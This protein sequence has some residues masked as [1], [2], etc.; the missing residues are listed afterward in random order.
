[1][2]ERPDVI[3]VGSGPAGANA[4]AALVE[5]GRRVLMLDYGDTDDR[6][7]QL[8]PPRTFREI[9]ESDEEQ[10][11]Y[12]LGDDFEGVPLGPLSTGAQLTPP[13][14]HVTASA[15]REM[16]V[17]S[18]DFRVAESLA[19]GGLGG[20]WGAG[21]FPF[22]DEELSDW[23]ISLADLL[24]HYDAVARRIGISVADDD[25]ERFFGRPRAAMPPLEVDSN[26]DAVLRA[27]SRKR[28]R[29]NGE[30]FFLGRTPLA[31]CTER[32]R[33]RGPESYRDMDFW[34]DIDRSVYRPR[35]TIA[36][37]QSDARGLFDYQHGLFVRR[38]EETQD[39]VNV[40]ASRRDGSEATFRAP[41]LLLGAG[42]LSTARIVLRSLSQ[43]RRRVPLLCN[44]YTYA[45]LVNLPM[46]G[47]EAR[48][49][50]HSLAQL[51]A[52]YQPDLARGG[53]GAVQAQLYSWRT[54]LTFRLMKEAPIAHRESL[55]I[56][57]LLMTAFG[58][59]G[60][61]HEDRRTERK[62]CLLRDDDRL[63]IHYALDADERARIESNERAILAGF[64][65]LGCW[66]IKR[67]HPGNGSSIHYAGTFPMSGDAKDGT[68]DAEG[69]L[70]G[71]RAVYLVD[72]SSFPY[73][74]AK[75]LT[76]TIMAN[77]DRVASRLALR[78]P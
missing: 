64:R 38:F 24:P 37:L 4:A 36:E 70:A 65:D 7:A 41:A 77:A 76:F 3:V 50:R 55:R 69:R 26:A 53:R 2:S 57:R 31:V 27:Y 20:A 39:G 23:P 29:L 56:M 60:I 9:R 6:Y 45:P 74:P 33:D 5:R 15:K 63:E 78:L 72:G 68:T 52:F 8:I 58:V 10:H 18:E 48:D 14:V 51:S 13:R 71:T 66:T 73:L 42:T 67:V 46:L 11:R 47:R 21:V 54:L 19:L 35:W 75:G 17:V 1:M 43:R 62:H 61:H 12:F 28:E 32:L 25:L 59:L 44:P 16:P 22:D 34:T 40:V 49:R 30:G